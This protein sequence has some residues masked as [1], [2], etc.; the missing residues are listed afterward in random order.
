MGKTENNPKSEYPPKL[1]KL[2]LETGLGLPFIFMPS[3]NRV[4]N[5]INIKH[6]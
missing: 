4:K 6:T 3:L 2:E 1:T 5:V